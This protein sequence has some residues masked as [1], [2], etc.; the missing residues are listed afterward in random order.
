MISVCG[1]PIFVVFF[2]S[3]IGIHHPGQGS[4]P[5]SLESD[6]SSLPGQHSS[7]YSN[8][9]ASC[10]DASPPSHRQDLKQFQQA[11]RKNLQARHMDNICRRMADVQ[12]G[13]VVQMHHHQGHVEWLDAEEKKDPLGQEH[14]Q[15]LRD[16]YRGQMEQARNHAEVDQ[17]DMVDL[18]LGE[19]WYLASHRVQ[20][21]CWLVHNHL[22]RQCPP[23]PFSKHL[24]A[25][26]HQNQKQTHMRIYHN[27][28]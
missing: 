22:S 13:R 20:S 8:D 10:N 9:I 6:H 23:P 16:H 15:A 14:N 26:A 7:C 21:D 25:H 12:T 1:H 2:I 4:D 11:E 3:G 19:R 28:A 24:P 5:D 17:L 18:S 27:T